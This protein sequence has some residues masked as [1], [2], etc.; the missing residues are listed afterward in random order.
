MNCGL[1]IGCGTDFEPTENLRNVKKFIFIDSQPLTSHGTARIDYCV[2]NK[3]MF[4]FLTVIYIKH[5]HH[6]INLN[7]TINII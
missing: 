1:Y 4:Y 6:K 5:V 3:T 2:K 7:F